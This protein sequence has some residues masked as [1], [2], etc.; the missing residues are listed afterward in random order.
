MAQVAIGCVW[1]GLE[2]L[3]PSKEF[4]WEPVPKREKNQPIATATSEI[5]AAQ[6]KKW[7]NVKALQF[8]HNRPRVFGTLLQSVLLKRLTERERAFPDINGVIYFS[9]EIVKTENEGR[10][11][12]MLSD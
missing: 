2:K 12:G 3:T 4:G 8:L 10:N 5:K 11:S 7:H 9:F 6:Q 1:N